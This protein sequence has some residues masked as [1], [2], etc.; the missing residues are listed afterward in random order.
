[1]TYV[2]IV[3]VN[4]F[5]FQLTGYKIKQSTDWLSFDSFKDEND[6]EKG[7]NCDNVERFDSAILCY[8]CY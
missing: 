4:R 7:N 1:M 6:W 3:F 8:D 5:F 2:F